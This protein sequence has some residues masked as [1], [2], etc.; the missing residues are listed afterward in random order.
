MIVV[1]TNTYMKC[2]DV[3]FAVGEVGAAKVTNKFKL[4]NLFQ[5][6]SGI[7]SGSAKL[8]NEKSQNR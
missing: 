3:W 4:F 8:A 7:V 2:C 6:F 1:S 5:D